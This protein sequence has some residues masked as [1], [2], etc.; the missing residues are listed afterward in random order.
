MRP[1]RRWVSRFLPICSISETLAVGYIVDEFS[2]M[3]AFLF[4]SFLP[5]LAT[6]SVL[7]LIRQNRPVAR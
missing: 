2:Y 7:G 4:V 1:G 3:P 6:V 5:V